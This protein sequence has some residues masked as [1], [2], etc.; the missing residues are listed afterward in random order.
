MDSAALAG[1]PTLMY[2]ILFDSE[3]PLAFPM[4][5]SQARLT[6]KIKSLIRPKSQTEGEVENQ[7]LTLLSSKKGE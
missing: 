6:C 7:I 5:D 2:S 3:F 4:G 1:G